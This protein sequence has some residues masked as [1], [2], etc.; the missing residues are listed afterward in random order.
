MDSS[1]PFYLSKTLW[2]QVIAVAVLL[3]SAKLPGVADFLK[4][5][6]SEVGAGWA[7]VN[8]V[9]RLISKDQLSIS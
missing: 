9:L 8:V 6:F 2:L 5:N 7:I 4:T 1:K 3:L